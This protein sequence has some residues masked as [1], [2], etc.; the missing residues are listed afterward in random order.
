MSLPPPSD[1]C[2]SFSSV[3][4][5]DPDTPSV[6]A[7]QDVSFAPN[8]TTTHGHEPK[9]NR[10]VPSHANAN[11]VQ[12]NQTQSKRKR[13]QSNV[14][15]IPSTSAAQ[16]RRI[17]R[18]NT[19]SNGPFIVLIKETNQPISPIKLMKYINQN[20]PSITSAKRS[21]GSLK[22]SFSSAFDANAMVLDDV[23]AEYQVNIPADHVEIEG[24]I[25]WF[26][27][28]D[29]N[30]LDE[31][32]DLGEGIFN[33]TALAPCKILDAERLARLGDTTIQTD[34]N[35][36]M[37]NTVK[38]VFEGKLLP[39]HI[40]I[41]GLRIRVRPFFKKP[42]FCEKCL[43]FGH[44]IKVCRMSAKCATCGLDH[45]TVQCTS[46]A[47]SKCPYCLSENQHDRKKC[48]FF[49]EVNESFKAKQAS[50][51]KS[52]LQQAANSA[53]RE[54]PITPTQNI[55]INGNF[56]ELRNRFNQLPVDEVEQTTESI[57]T[58]Q[59]IL[60]NPYAKVVKDNLITDKDRA[61]LKRTRPK[62][63]LKPSVKQ[64]PHVTPQQQQ[65]TASKS[66]ISPTTKDNLSSALTA[67][68][69]NF[70]RN[71][72]IS[73]IWITLLEAILEPL[74]QSLTHQLPTLLS[75]LAPSVLNISP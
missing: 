45:S 63:T 27:L 57:I 65:S 25:D 34:R 10:S 6:I 22:I 68:I 59:P 23:F 13:K 51:C 26:D 16:L 66:K 55:Q 4:M 29:I 37:S 14:D 47:N 54:T 67:A 15:S 50:R 20:Y 9:V 11:T 58:Q 12:E 7:K 61:S 69:L 17:R 75:A 46:K 44:T 31:L 49:A 56:P 39:T 73:S 52:M 36:M 71:A 42:M 70:A 40:L 8:T 72:G 74:L 48:P 30:D 19:S 53:N 43:K 60:K 2:L 41:F 35:L 28:C 18:Y 24:A 3:E 33:N 21:P 38:I 1:E 5:D 32:C 62:V 64:S